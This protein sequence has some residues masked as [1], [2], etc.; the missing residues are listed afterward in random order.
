MQS[1]RNRSINLRPAH[2]NKHENEH[3]NHLPRSPCPIKTGMTIDSSP[4]QHFRN[5]RYRDSRTHCAADT[6]TDTDNRPYPSGP[7]S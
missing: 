4:Y 2:E 6:D 5:G 1:T 7:E 3:E